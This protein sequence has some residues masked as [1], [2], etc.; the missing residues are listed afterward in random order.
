MGNGMIRAK[1]WPKDEEEPEIWTLEVEHANAHRT[2]HPVSMP[3][4]H[5]A[6][7]SLY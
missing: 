5:R 3:C 1:A 2:V 6:K 7:E 4:H